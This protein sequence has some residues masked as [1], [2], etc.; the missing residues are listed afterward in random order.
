MNPGGYYILLAVICGT[1][2]GPLSL[3]L[4]WRGQQAFTQAQNSGPLLQFQVDRKS[5]LSI[6]NRGQVNI[7]DVGIFVTTYHLRFGK[8]ARLLDEGRA[9]IESF[10][11]PSARVAATPRIQRQGGR[12]ELSLT[13]SWPGLVFF[14]GVPEVEQFRTVYCLRI[15]FRNAVNKQRWVH[16]L[17]TPAAREM[18]N[19]WDVPSSSGTA[20]GGGYE[21][22]LKVIEVR[23]QIR[24]HQSELFDDLPTELYRSDDGAL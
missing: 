17:V 11:T 23:K 18:P 15:V 16:Y 10:T 12:Y 14:D 7:E 4:L 6:V 13:A 1:V 5:K 8:D 3:F 21:A 24:A 22:S 9:A 19:A 2:G 20:M